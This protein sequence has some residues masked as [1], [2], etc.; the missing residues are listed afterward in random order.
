MRRARF[1]YNE[2]SRVSLSASGSLLPTLAII[3]GLN[4]PGLSQERSGQ[5]DS[6]Y[7]KVRSLVD[8]EYDSLFGLYRHLH[9]NPE[10][11]FQEEKT[12]ARVKQELASTGFQVTGNVG[13]HGV[14]GVL[15]NGKGPTLMLRTDMDALPVVEETGLEYASRV[16]VTDIHGKVVGV[17]H[18]CG[19][20][21]HMTCVT[22]TAR[23]LSRMKSHWQ[24]TLVVI[25]QPAEERGGG[26]RAML[27]DGLFVRFPRPDY[28]LAMHDDAG[29]EA[30]KVGLATGYALAG[31]DSVDL[32][33]R[34]VGGHGAYPHTTKD[35]IVLAAQTVL[36]LQTIVSRELRAV[37]P[38]VITV[39]SIHGG[40]KHNIIPEEVKLE[41][42]V[43]YY[44]DAVRTHIHE[45][46][47]RI[48]K[49]IA[50]AGGV[51]E[52]LA[53]IMKVSEAEPVFPVHNDP[54]LS[55]RVFRAMERILGTNR[56]LELEPVMGGEDFGYYG[57]TEHRIPLCMFWVGTVSPKRMEASRTKGGKPLPSL[58]SSIFAPDPE[59]T[60]RTG[61]QA[62]TSASLE[63]LQP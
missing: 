19:H 18:A 15:K 4:V 38:A 17:M 8:Q 55:Q 37:D 41:I 45:S 12:A 59:P 7:D 51:P 28:A 49:G 31:V 23:L 61:V 56:V 63:L 44:S 48:A 32:T 16:R 50:T 42:T 62:M 13:G 33:I 10:L 30:G 29:M 35:P 47:E 20:D 34:G 52:D 1:T 60:I 58:H 26:A 5:Q 21:I 24:G 3:L 39:G 43:R 40:T 54:E 57:R 11:S 27:A 22:G 2:S 25:G 36:A 46:I 9:S 53:P 14:V 6:V